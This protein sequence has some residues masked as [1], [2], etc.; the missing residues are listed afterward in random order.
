MLVHILCI[1]L[2]WEGNNYLKSR[3]G[4]YIELIIIRNLK[5]VKKT[6]P[7]MSLYYSYTNHIR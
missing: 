4:I 5:T 3:T 6:A 1:S 2:G 7:K